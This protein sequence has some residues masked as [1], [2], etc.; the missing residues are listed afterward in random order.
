MKRKILFISIVSLLLLW[1]FFGCDSSKKE[2]PPDQ[3]PPVPE[4]CS[5]LS[6]QY[7]QALAAAHSS[8]EASQV[9]VTRIA[10]QFAHCMEEAGLS[11]AEARGIV[12]NMERTAG[13][14]GEKE[15]GR[16]G[17]YSR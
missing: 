11:E 12:K 1:I 10:S 8:V 14:Q 7:S 2:I 15:V 5:G 6:T 17:D 13:E 9:Q 4:T 16:E 3:L